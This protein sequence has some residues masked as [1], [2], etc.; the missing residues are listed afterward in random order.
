MSAESDPYQILQVRPDAEEDVIRAAYRALAR[1]LH[2]DH[3]ADPA[4][5]E[6]MV[7]VNRAWEILSDPVRRAALD[8]QRTSGHW[9]PGNGKA[10]ETSTSPDGASAHGAGS[11]QARSRTS[12]SGV[13][14]GPRIE[15]RTADGRVVAWRTAADGTGAAGPPPGRPSGSILPFGRFIAWSIGEVARHDPGY[16]EWLDQ[17]P[18]GAPYHA[19]IDATLQRSGWRHGGVSGARSMRGSR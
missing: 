12:G 19:E 9:S 14:G 5:A 13:D 11:N 6:R 16:L 18:E 3:S 2:P 8:R 7:Q 15:R 10:S 1:N 17:R 4:S